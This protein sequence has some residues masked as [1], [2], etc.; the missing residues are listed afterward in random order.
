MIIHPT[1]ITKSDGRVRVSSVVEIETPGKVFTANNAATMELWIDWPEAYFVPDTPDA[2][3]FA[4]ICLTAAMCLKE[5]L[6]I[7]TPISQ[8][9]LINMLEAM[10]IYAN[11]FPHL[12]EI[13]PLEV[14]TYDLPRNPQTRVGSFYSGGVD[15]LYNIAEHRRLETQFGVVPV[16]DLW[17]IQGMDIG[18]QQ[19]ELWNETKDLLQ[20]SVAQNEQLRCV[21]IRTNAREFQG[22][23]V[24]WDELGFSAI[25]GGIAKC[26][27]P[28]VNTALIG[29]YAKY[30]DIMPH[31]SSPM[32]DPMWS[33]DR[34]TVRHFSCRADRMEKIRVISEC[35]PELLKTLRVCYSN[36]DG[37]YNCGRCEKCLRTQM[38]LLLCGSIDKCEMFNK[39][40]VADD[41][42]QLKLPW[43]KKN[44]YTWDFWRDIHAA[45]HE[46]GMD[47]F[48]R[49]LTRQFKR[50]RV[51]AVVKRMIDRMRSAF[52]Q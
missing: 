39:K 16:S 48:E 19:D 36:F 41:L 33:C 22:K 15:S 14:A 5:R 8:S 7:K 47:D 31:A 21:D 44:N 46:A 52:N 35:A 10:E 26:F 32:I 9:L 2:G 23:I 34:Q 27:A 20:A 3:P 18:L 51:R 38:Q 50:N 13:I 17:L 37:E 30:K 42:R 29:S 11:D 25:L 4:L 43:K 1:E 28:I 49:E 24:S 6:V 40:I 45:C 12:C